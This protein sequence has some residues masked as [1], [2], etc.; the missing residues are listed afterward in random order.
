M[1]ERVLEEQRRY[2][3][4]RA[5]EYD[6]W[7]FK[8]GRYALDPAAEACWWADVAEVEDGLDSLGALGSVVELAA[9]TGIWTRK[10]VERGGRVVAVDVN[11]ETLALNTTDAEHV[12]A[13]VFEWSAHETFN[14][15]F[16]SYWLSH[17]PEARFDEFWRLV[18]SLLRPGGRV[19]LID[20][21]PGFHE[22]DGELELR[23]L[24]DGR[25][26]EIVKRCRGPQ[27]LAARVAGLGFE[28]DLRVAAG[29]SILYGAGS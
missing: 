5:P 20:T 12:V 1:S 22:H 17:V 21:P 4:E 16:F 19:F 8:R 6:D 23:Q 3:A 28:L 14:L 18:R 9:G 10:L 26:F 11:R 13:D 29:G 24:A 2:Y 25:Q 7:W 15:C 27:E